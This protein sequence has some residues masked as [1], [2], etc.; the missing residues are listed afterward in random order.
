MRQPIKRTKRSKVE[1]YRAPIVHLEDPREDRETTV[2]G[3]P[4]HSL[5][6]VHKYADYKDNPEDAC[7]TC[8]KLK[9]WHK[10][11]VYKAYPAK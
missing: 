7:L 11:G 1:P 5:K 4:L 8:S 10:H 9:E 2:C 6:G 3:I